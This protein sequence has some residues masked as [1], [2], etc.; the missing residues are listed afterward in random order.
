[1][2]HGRPSEG[3]SALPALLAPAVSSSAQRRIRIGAVEEIGMFG[4]TSGHLRIRLHQFEARESRIEITL[5]KLRTFVAALPR[6]PALH[7]FV[8][9]I[10]AAVAA[11]AGG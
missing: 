11:H 3:R 6:R 9:A 10:V 1:M 2:A 7:A 5:R 4:A 8:L